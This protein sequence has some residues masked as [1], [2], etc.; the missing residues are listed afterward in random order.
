[1]ASPE[2]TVLSNE[3]IDMVKVSMGGIEINEDTL[4][5]DLIEKKGPRAN[6]ISEKHTLKH[7]RKFWAPNLFDRSV[8]RSANAKNCEEM[9]NE[10]TIKIMETY[11]SKPPSDDVVKELKKVEADWFKRVGIQEYLKNK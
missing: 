7:F 11:Q 5:L 1:M 4:P 10:A 9:V 8:T 3:I 2:L 6:Y